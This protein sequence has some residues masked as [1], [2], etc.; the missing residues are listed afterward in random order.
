VWKR[1]PDWIRRAVP[2]SRRKADRAT[3]LA[4]LN[5]LEETCDAVR[6]TPLPAVG[7]TAHV[8]EVVHL[9]VL[10]KTVG[11]TRSEAYQK[12]IDHLASVAPR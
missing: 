9:Q 7:G 6:Y 5:W 8:L 11:R 4:Q 10:H 12:M 1:I 3:L 2:A